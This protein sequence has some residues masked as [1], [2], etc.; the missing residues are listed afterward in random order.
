MKKTLLKHEN[1]VNMTN[2]DGETALLPAIKNNNTEM[3]KI[4]IEAG[5]DISNTKII[6]LATNENNENKSLI[7]PELIDESFTKKIN[8]PKKSNYKIFTNCKFKK[9]FFVDKRDGNKYEAITIGTQKWMAENLKYTSDKKLKEIKDKQKW[10][11]NK[12]S[13]G[14]CYYNNTKSKSNIYGVLYQWE[15]AKTAFPKDWHL[16]SEKEWVEL[17]NYP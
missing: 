1:I 11:D 16:A 12:V 13:D 14:Y 6:E 3:V 2:I 15:T 4:L 17:I 10:K 7:I 8:V 5:A 9:G